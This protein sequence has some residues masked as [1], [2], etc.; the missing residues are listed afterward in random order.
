MKNLIKLIVI[1]LL[2]ESIL[3][4]GLNFLELSTYHYFKL[5]K[6]KI[7]KT[8]SRELSVWNFNNNPTEQQG[9]NMNF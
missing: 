6:R 2:I 4:V 8:I 7:D 5:R 1:L 3:F 9:I